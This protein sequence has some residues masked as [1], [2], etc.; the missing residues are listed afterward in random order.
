MSTATLDPI[1]LRAK[2]LPKMR[3]HAARGRDIG[4]NIIETI[5]VMAIAASLLLAAVPQYQK[6]M[7]RANVQNIATDLR[8]VSLQVTSDY[9]L[10]GQALYTAAGVAESAEEVTLT[11]GNSVTVAVPTGGTKFTLTGASTQVTNYTVTYDSAEGGVK[12]AKK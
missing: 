7:E 3:T 4:M 8:N 1:V 10:T 2:Y 5:A 11:K 6:Y 12:I 9:S